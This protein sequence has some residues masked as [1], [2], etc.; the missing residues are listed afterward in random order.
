MY[1]APVAIFLKV[2]WGGMVAF[3][4][5]YLILRDALLRLQQSW[6]RIEVNDKGQLRLTQRSGNTMD[7]KVSVA[8]FVTS[9]LTILHVQPANKSWLSCLDSLFLAGSG[10][11]ILLPDSANEEDFRQLRVWLRWWR[12]SQTENMQNIK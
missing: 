1:F 12:H 8:S 4:M 10:A 2:I 5:G 9:Y 7:A 6:Q 11:P 3:A